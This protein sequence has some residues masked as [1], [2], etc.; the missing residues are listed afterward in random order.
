MI[1]FV[2]E[3]EARYGE[4]ETVSPLVR[5]VLANNPSK[6]TF[7]GTGTYIVGHGRVAVV[8]PGPDLGE[9]RDALAAALA[10]EEVTAILV[11]HCHS[12]HSP[13]AAWLRAETGARPTPSVLTSTCVRRSRRRRGPPRRPSTQGSRLMSACPTVT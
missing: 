5:R 4:A 10:G 3:Y 2:T 1:P 11:T 12:D 8:D 9:H 7:K 6:F 13:L